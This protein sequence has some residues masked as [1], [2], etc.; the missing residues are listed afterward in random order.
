MYLIV[1]LWCNENNLQMFLKIIT[2][3]GWTGLI[4]FC[5]NSQHSLCTFRRLQ[6]RG[7]INLCIKNYEEENTVACIIIQAGRTFI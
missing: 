5:L 7:F 2:E 4:K 1:N 6:S 3:F